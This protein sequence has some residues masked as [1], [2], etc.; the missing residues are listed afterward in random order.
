[1]GGFRPLDDI[2]CARDVPE[3]I[4]RHGPTFHSLGLGSLRHVAVDYHSDTVNLYFH[5]PG[6]SQ[7]SKLQNS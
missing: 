6:L 3:S 2:L 1:M 4:R 5:A 7:K